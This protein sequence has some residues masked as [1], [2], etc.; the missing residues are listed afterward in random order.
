MVAILPAKSTKTRVIHENPKKKNNK[1]QPRKKI[2]K[3]KGITEITF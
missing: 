3:S 1:K 2:K